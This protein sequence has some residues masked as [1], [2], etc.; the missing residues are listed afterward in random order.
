MTV[1]I[2]FCLISRSPVNITCHE[3]PYLSC[4]HPYFSLNGYWPSS[5]SVVPPFESCF[6]NESTSS[7]VLQAT[8]NDTEGLNLNRGPAL[9]NVNSWPKSSI[10]TRSTEPEGVL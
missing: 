7:L 6:H 4:V 8:R 3:R 9:I 1:G 5:M 2:I 10:V